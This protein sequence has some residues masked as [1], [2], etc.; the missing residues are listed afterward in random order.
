MNF[1]RLF[2][3]REMR[4]EPKPFL[5]HLEDLRRTVIKMLGVL[6]LMTVLAFCFQTQIVHVIER[7]LL[8]ID[9]QMKSLVN[10]GVTDPLTIAFELSFY[11]GL[12]LSFPFLIFFLADFILPALTP[13]ERGMLY[14]VATASLGLFLA[15]VVFA[16]FGVLPPTLDY[17]FKYSKDMSWQPQ[18]SVREYFSFT[19]QFVISFGLAF[20]LPLCVLILVKL[21]IVNVALLR[22]TRAYAI[23]LIFFFAAI[24]TPTSDI[25]TLMLM[26]GPMYL[27]YEL[28]IFIAWMMER[29]ER[30]LVIDN[31]G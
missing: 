13:Q 1:K 9:P 28:C 11:A 27:L 5:D 25:L 14:P 21:G 3:F 12:I 22:R 30:Q 20:E 23:V 4:D 6:V 8:A 31:R 15:G 17:F 7:P 29:K 26:G 16:Y 10:F 18:W 2:D 24:I 19:T